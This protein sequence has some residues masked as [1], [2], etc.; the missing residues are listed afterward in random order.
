[1]RRLWR[2]MD[3]DD[4]ARL[5][6]TTGLIVAA[7]TL[8]T[9]LATLSYFFTWK[10]DQSAL[11][12]PVA[13]KSVKI[14]N[15]AGKLGY[16]WANL[17]VREWFG[18]GSLALVLILFAVSARLLLQRWHY[19]MTRTILLTV[20]GAL[21][22]SFLLAFISDLASWGNV[23]GGGL[24]G[25]CGETVVSWS[26][27]LFG[28]IITAILLLLLLALWL[29]FASDKFRDWLDSLGQVKE[30]ENPVIV[31]PVSHLPIESIQTQR[32]NVIEPVSPLPI[33]RTRPQRSE[34]SELPSA[35]GTGVTIESCPS[36]HCPSAGRGRR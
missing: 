8:F 36:C 17:L 28:S 18:L 12:A 32:D 14:S 23:F 30:P 2:D 22:A 27:N 1:M 3:D 24:G 25:E 11:A 34:A 10:V 19:S 6:K 15:F 33:G 26:R 31:G 21:V 4:K 16:K 13:D 20:S 7:F 5:V 9:L 29:F 35:P